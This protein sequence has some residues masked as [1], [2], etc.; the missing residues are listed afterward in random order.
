MRA[1]LSP[2]LHLDVTTAC[3][4][5]L[6]VVCHIVYGM[7]L[8]VP[9]PAFSRPMQRRLMRHWSHGLLDILRVGLE[10]HGSHPPARQ[11]R[12]FVANHISWLDAMT[13]A[14]AAPAYFVAK[15]EVGN[16]PLLGWLCRRVDTLFIRRGVRRDTVNVNRQIAELLLKD[17][18]V[19]IFPEGTTTAGGA[20]GHFHSSL[21][22]G[23][24][25]IGTAIQPVAIRYHDGNGGHNEDAAYVGDMT[26][27]QSLWKILRSPSLHAT[28]VY[29][30]AL[31]C[32]GKS[33][34]IVASQAQ[35]AIRSAL[36]LF[37]EHPHMAAG[38]YSAAAK[39]DTFPVLRPG[40]S[41]LLTPMGRRENHAGK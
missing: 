6:C 15:S 12:L 40:Y 25:D 33:R 23:A 22:Q 3:W 21:L 7:L 39:K 9:Y 14:A 34:R 20:P 38:A 41:L 30:P 2:R 37:Q 8:A 10:T 36:S 11:G 35:D 29:L 1:L 17:E 16:W 26:F 27:V 28:I 19:V 31:P 32:E 4:R 5:A 13:L 18:C 24:M